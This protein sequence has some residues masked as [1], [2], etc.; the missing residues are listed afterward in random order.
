MLGHII[1]NLEKRKWK[2]EKEGE[3]NE[4]R[5]LGTLLY[6]VKLCKSWRDCGSKP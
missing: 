4:D 2:M 5:A 1:E 3:S 6:G